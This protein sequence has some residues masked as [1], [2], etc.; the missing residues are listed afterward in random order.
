MSEWIDHQSPADKMIIEVCG[1]VRTITFLL[2][3]SALA[4]P[5]P[6]S[7]QSRVSSNS[8]SS[9]SF[10][11]LGS[12]QDRPGRVLDLPHAGLPA[13]SHASNLIK[14]LFKLGCSAHSQLPGQ[15]SPSFLL[16]LFLSSQ[17]HIASHRISS[18][19][20]CARN[21]EL[22]PRPLVGGRGYGWVDE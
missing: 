3:L 14:P 6:G 11:F 17:T 7:E 2:L 12:H 1:C 9:C 5:P 16:F 8:S 21:R 4:S 10:S 22:V 13:P 15:P 20:H 18:A 19:L